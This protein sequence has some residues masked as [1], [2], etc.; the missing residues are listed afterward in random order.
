MPQVVASA[1]GDD[2]VVVITMPPQQKQQPPATQVRMMDVA[3]L[4][5]SEKSA[6]NDI[7]HRMSIKKENFEIMH[8]IGQGGQGVVFRAKHRRG[9][10]AGKFCAIKKIPI[11]ADIKMVELSGKK[12]PCEMLFHKLAATN[13]EGVAEVYKWFVDDGCFNMV[14]ELPDNSMDLFKYLNKKKLLNDSEA[15]YIFKQIATITS[16]C[17]DNR[18]VHRDLKLENVL[19][20]Q[21]NKEVKLI[22]FG[23]ATFVPVSDFSNFCHQI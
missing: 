10:R 1:A 16:K 14:M 12:I 4:R 6:L 2:P 18:V 8:E 23:S 17:H 19:I 11:N 9:K 3:E 22:D 15:K 5:K 13:N 21:R 20:N 7:V